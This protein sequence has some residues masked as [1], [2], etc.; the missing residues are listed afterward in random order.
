MGKV[1]YSTAL[2]QANT[3][4]GNYVQRFSLADDKDEAIVRIMHDDTRSFDIISSHNLQVNNRY[5]DVNCLRDFGEPVSKCPL[6]DA[7]MKPR[8]RIY[9]HLIQYTKDDMGNIVA[10]PKVWDRNINYAE[11][12]SAY[13]DNYGP[14]SDMIC[15]IIRHGEKGSLQTTYEIIPNLSKVN[16]PDNVYVKDTSY[17]ENFDPIG[18]VVWSKSADDMRTYIATGDFPQ[19]DKTASSSASYTPQREHNAPR[20]M[21]NNIDIEDE[22][23]TAVRQTP[24]WERTPQNFN[25]PKRTY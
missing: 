2:T 8:T 22:P 17:F 25:R 10:V 24:P 23:T 13:I 3:G 16:Y 12:L 5:R 18:S 20:I 9:I 19:A 14:L 7:G 1:D 11:K 6:C 21:N 4:S 15:K